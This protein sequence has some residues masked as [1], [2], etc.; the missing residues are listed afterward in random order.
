M[1]IATA[2]AGAV[3]WVRG[4][5]IAVCA[6]LAVLVHHETAAIALSSVPSATHA[7]HA[8]PGV[9]SSSSAAAMPK[10]SAADHTDLL[11]AHQSAHSSQ[12]NACATPGMQHC[13]TA[14]VEVVKLAMPPQ[15]HAEQPAIPAQ[16]EP[17]P[18]P[19][20]TIGRAPPDLSVLS[21]LRI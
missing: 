8:M 9:A 11:G 15:L 14:N 1:A 21:Q 7:G 5:V 6:A 10:G 12:H 2:R 18:L 16:A 17:G 3:R 19:A 13:S 20:G 4:T